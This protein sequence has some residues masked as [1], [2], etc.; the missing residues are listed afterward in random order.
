MADLKWYVVRSV[1]GQEKKA[2]AYLENEVIRQSLDEF[3]PMLV[4]GEF[5]S[6]GALPH[7]F[8]AAVENVVGTDRVQQILE[9]FL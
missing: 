1:S 7:R 3:V 8:V 9:R 6:D 4:G 5:G 2:K